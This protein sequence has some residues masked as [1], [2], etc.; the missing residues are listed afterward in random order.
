MSQELLF[1]FERRNIFPSAYDDVLLTIDDEHISILIPGG[2]V[3][4]MKPPASHG[5]CVRFGLL[6]VALHDVV[7]ARDYFA[8]GSSVARHVAAIGVNHSK[9]D[10]QDREAGHGLTSEPMF[11]LPSKSWLHSG[12]GQRGRR[13]CE[14]VSSEA[15]A[16]KFF[17][18]LL[19][20]GR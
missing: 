20:Q 15:S 17:L 7:T 5:F 8:D 6:P 13:F 2:R 9:L 16:S 10:S 11:S 3:A 4:G 14:P 19:Y 1:D 18:Y 12:S